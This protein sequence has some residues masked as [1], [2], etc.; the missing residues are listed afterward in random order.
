[1]DDVLQHPG[2]LLVHLPLVVYLAEV[3]DESHQVE[4]SVLAVDF[5]GLGE[6]LEGISVVSSEELAET[7]II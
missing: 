4:T 7:Y 6:I 1:M 5:E 2:R 3:P